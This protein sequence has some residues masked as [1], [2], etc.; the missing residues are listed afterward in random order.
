MPDGIHSGAVLPVA[1][2]LINF[3][4]EQQSALFIVAQH[5]RRHAHQLLKISFSFTRMRGFGI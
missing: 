1:R 5:T 2:E 3:G 4:R